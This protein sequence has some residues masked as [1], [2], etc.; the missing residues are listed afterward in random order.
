MPPHP[1][2][3]PSVEK[4]IVRNLCGSFLWKKVTSAT[5]AGAF[6]G[7]KYRPQPLRKRSVGKNEPN[8]QK[9]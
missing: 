5:L 3:K 8:F 6:G 1:Y 7:E 4:N 9:G 2:G